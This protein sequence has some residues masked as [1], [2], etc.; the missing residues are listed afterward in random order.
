MSNYEKNG[1]KGNLG[2]FDYVDDDMNLDR[3]D[4]E[5][6]IVNNVLLYYGPP[7]YVHYGCESIKAS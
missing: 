1:M 4:S 7:S 2:V 3:G 6:K 5:S